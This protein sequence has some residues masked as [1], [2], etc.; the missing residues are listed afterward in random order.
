MGK[1][2]N[3]PGGANGAA[4]GCGCTANWRLQIMKYKVALQ[5]TEEGCSVS[6][7]GLPGCRSQGKDE[8]EALSNIQ[9][10]IREHL[11]ESAT[12]PVGHRRIL[13]RDFFKEHF[14]AGDLLQDAEIREVE[15]TV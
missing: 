8:Q 5:Y 12:R 9:D 7:L 3:R 1:V 10:A 15:V 14:A 11:A 4:R 6:V 13:H 2:N